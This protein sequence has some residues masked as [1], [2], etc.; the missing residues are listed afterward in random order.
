M[1]FKIKSNIFIS[2]FFFFLKIVQGGY[3]VHMIDKID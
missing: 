1:V 3:C 2:E